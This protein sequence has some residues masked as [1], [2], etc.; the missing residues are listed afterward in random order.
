[1]SCLINGGYVR[2]PGK[3]E[4][5]YGANECRETTLEALREMFAQ[6]TDCRTNRGDFD[7][8]FPQENGAL[9]GV[10]EVTRNGVFAFH[11]GERTGVT[12]Q[13]LLGGC[14]LPLIRKLLARAVDRRG[15]R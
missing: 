9:I 14:S 15:A 12:W 1:M 4:T 13:E 7:S 6:V 10:I 11:R 8:V 2:G 5:G 3:L